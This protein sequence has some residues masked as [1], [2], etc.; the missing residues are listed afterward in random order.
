MSRRYGYRE[1]LRRANSA[2]RARPRSSHLIWL[3]ATFLMLAGVVTATLFVNPLSTLASTSTGVSSPIVC[4]FEQGPYWNTVGSGVPPNTPYIQATPTLNPYTVGPVIPSTSIATYAYG[5]GSGTEEY[6]VSEVSFFCTSIPSSGTNTVSVQVSD[7]TPLGATATYG[8]LFVQTG[9][10]SNTDPT[11]TA[12]CDGTSP[13]YL[14]EPSGGGTIWA[15]NAQ[16]GGLLTSGGGC[17]V[18]FTTSA[19]SIGVTSASSTVP[20]FTVS[21]GFV[22]MPATN[23]LSSCASYTTFSLGFQAMNS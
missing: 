3:G 20:V 15:W 5:A 19:I 1:F 23:C 12:A 17:P 13:N 7:T 10:P 18:P 6:M 4:G 2:T 16:S 11:T 8:V 14:Y 9:S 21:F 22:G